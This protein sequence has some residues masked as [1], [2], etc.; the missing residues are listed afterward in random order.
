MKKVNK[1]EPGMLVWVARKD[2]F[3]I[4]DYDRSIAGQRT[5]NVFPGNALLVLECYVTRTTFL[6]DNIVVVCDMRNGD[7]SSEAYWFV[8]PD[9]T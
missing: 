1:L 4:G 5:H 2:T 3:F 7:C 8:E 9:N 6:V